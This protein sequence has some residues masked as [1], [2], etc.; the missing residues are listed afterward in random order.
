MTDLE[1]LN[2]CF[3]PLDRRVPSQPCFFRLIGWDR[4]TLALLERYRAQA[5]KNG[6]CL[7]DLPNPTREETDRFYQEAGTQ[8][9]PNRA[10]IDRQISLWLGQ[11]RP[12]RRPALS[13]A[14]WNTLYLL[15]KQNVNGNILKNVY[16]KFMCWLRG[17]AGRA[18]AGLGGAEPPKVLFQGDVSRHEVLF[19]HLLHQAGCDVWYLHFLS[20]ASY[21]KADPEGRYSRL[22]AG[23]NHEP[24]PQPAPAPPPAPVPPPAPAARKQPAGQ[25]LGLNQWVGG[26]P[27]W[28]ALLLPL[29]QRGGEGGPSNLFAL[30]LGADQREVYRN[31]LFRLKRSLDESGR[32]WLLMDQRIQ[33]PTPAETETFRVPGLARPAMV[34]A[35][36]ER[37]PRG[38]PWTQKAQKALALVM[39]R[40]PE[41]N[42][43]RFFNYSVRLACWLRR[44][45]GQL[46]PPNASNGAYPPAL[47][48]YGPITEPEAALLWALAQMGA[49]VL[50]ISSQKTDVF[51]TH[52]LPHIWLEAS[53]EDSLPPEPFPQREEKVRART[54]AYDAQ[55][56]LDHLLYS[57]TGMFRDRQFTRSQ[58]VTLKTTYDEVGQLWPEEAQYRPSFRTEAGVVYVPN[59]FSKICGVE[60]GD[61]TLYWDHI[62][63]MLT[64]GTY[65]ITALPFLTPVGAEGIS[66]NAAQAFL[67]NGRLDPRAL[68]ASRFYRYGYLPEDTQNYILEKIQALIDYDL[69]VDGGPDLPAVMLSVLMNLDKELL[70][71]LQSFDFT[72]AIPKLLIV[73]TTET[74]FS[75][76]ECVLLAFLNLVGFD[77]A[78]FTPTGYRNLEAHIRSD[79]FDTLIAGDYLYDLTVPDLRNR[80]PSGKNG[81]NGK[82]WRRLF[83]G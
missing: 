27:V 82:G 46:F 20:D 73:D 9:S 37:M 15:Q 25:V 77:I 61:L 16:T 2:T 28:D 38:L 68:T 72:R 5:G 63:S 71:L 34:H 17:P 81:K 78:V 48:Y 70:R 23:A 22:V 50:Y 29:S 65:L 18:L 83:G 40:H 3:L 80:R 43:S 58:P 12:D 75:L 8:F 42:D 10:L 67:H 62:H 56:E 30:M 45:A 13:E 76:E 52:F 60:K 51:E 74:L 66:R 54:T 1:R 4:E 21:N 53:F 47:L 33:P 69:I 6:V 26:R 32:P 57:D 7:T 35:L 31:R 14:V 19:L 44:C 41:P 79:S 64:P 49:D 59:L 24:P 36:A 55:Q 11:V 39:E